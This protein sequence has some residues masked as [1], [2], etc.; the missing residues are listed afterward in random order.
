MSPQDYESFR[1]QLEAQL[2]ADIELLYEAYRAKLRAYEIVWRARGELEGASWESRPTSLP[3]FLPPLLASPEPAPLE[4]AAPLPP[5][6]APAPPKAEPAAVYHGL[7][8][9]LERVAEEFDKHDLLKALGYEPRRATLYRA[10]RDLEEDG[11]IAVV[12]QGSGRQATRYR[13]LAPA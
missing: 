1:Q 12:E 2:R 11:A 3:P 7:I 9:A 13:R 10:L 4:S 6:A 5:A 8:A